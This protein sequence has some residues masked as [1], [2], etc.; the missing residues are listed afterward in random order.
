MQLA[1]RLRPQLMTVFNPELLILLIYPKITV[2]LMN[3][4]S[5]SKSLSLHQTEH[6]I[7]SLIEEL[8][9]QVDS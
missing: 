7:N 6:C 4:E 1:S 8:N 3:T 9:I 5:W 2:V